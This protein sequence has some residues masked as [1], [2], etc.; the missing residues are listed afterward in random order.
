MEEVSAMKFLKYISL[1]LFL[2]LLFYNCKKSKNDEKIAD[3]RDKYC[4]NWF[5]TTIN[6]DSLGH[7]WNPFDTI[8]FNGTIVKNSLSDSIIEIQ[9][10]SIRPLEVYKIDPKIELNGNLAFSIYSGFFQGKINLQD[11][12]Q[13]Q[14]LQGLYMSGGNSF[15]RKTIGKKINM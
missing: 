5:F 11:N 1:F 14:M 9:Y 2:G 6:G 10:D 12:I 3:Y 8:Y 7:V 13:L 15:V 4:G